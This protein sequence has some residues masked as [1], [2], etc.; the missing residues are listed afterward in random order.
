MRGGVKIEGEEK[1]RKIQG[2]R[3][4]ER[5]RGRVREK[6]GR[7]TMSVAYFSDSILDCIWIL[8]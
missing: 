7:Y 2:E 1:K 5:E 4:R 6:R 3:E 8:C